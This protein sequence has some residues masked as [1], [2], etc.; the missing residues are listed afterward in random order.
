MAS[1]IRTQDLPLSRRTPSA[2]DHGGGVPC[3]SEGY[4]V[5]GVSGGDGGEAGSG[6]LGGSDDGRC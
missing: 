4:R 1:G 2:V 5:S 6:R 3:W